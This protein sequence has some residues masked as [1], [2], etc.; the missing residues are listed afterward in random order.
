[1]K[2][3]LELEPISIVE[4]CETDLIANKAALQG[5]RHLSSC[6][7]HHTISKPQKEQA[8]MIARQLLQTHIEQENKYSIW[9]HAGAKQHNIARHDLFVLRNPHCTI[10]DSVKSHHQPSTKSQPKTSTVAPD[11]HTPDQIS[12]IWLE[13]AR[14]ARICRWTPP[15]P[16]DTASVI[17]AR[18]AL[19]V[20][21][22]CDGLLTIVE[23]L[24]WDSD[25][26]M[27]LSIVIMAAVWVRTRPELVLQQRHLTVVN[28]S[29]QDLPRRRQIAW[30]PWNGQQHGCGVGI[31]KR[32]DAQIADQDM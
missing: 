20:V 4:R 2:T 6:S 23:V 21:C 22:L 14:R 25:G 3:H 9:L 15:V 18:T 24:L 12:R 26:K 27:V 13:P 11:R 32:F 28:A 31:T 30:R 7:T 1:M 16:E 29:V 8:N 17:V 10:I 19:V 5:M